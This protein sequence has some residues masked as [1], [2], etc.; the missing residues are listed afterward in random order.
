[1]LLFYDMSQ[2]YMV[3]GPYSTPRQY[4]NHLLSG[5]HIIFFMVNGS[6][7]PEIVDIYYGKDLTFIEIF[8]SRKG[9]K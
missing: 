5:T 4:R 6:G 8:F 9:V 2:V 3:V 7:P 1:M